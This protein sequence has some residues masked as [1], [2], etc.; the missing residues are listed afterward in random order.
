MF[1]GPNGAAGGVGAQHSQCFA[2]WYGSV[3]GLKVVAPYDAEDN[4]GLMKAAIRDDNP[5]VVLESEILYGKS[6]EVEDY[7]LDKDF[8]LPI[9]KAKVMREGSDVTIIGYGQSVKT[10][11]AAADELAK[12]GIFAEVR[13]GALVAPGRNLSPLPIQPEY[14]N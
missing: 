2:A 3:P 6:F 1:R 5:V 8:V 9:G 11:L 14:G 13:D 7:V 12:D 4:R 10:C